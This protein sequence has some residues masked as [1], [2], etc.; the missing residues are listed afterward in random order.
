MRWL[1]GLVLFLFVLG[2]LALLGF[3]FFSDLP[4]PERDIVVPVEIG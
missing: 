2:I 1:L 3:A 4:A